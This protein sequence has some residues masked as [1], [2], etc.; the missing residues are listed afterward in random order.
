[1]FLA[2]EVQRQLK[3][4]RISRQSL[5][6]HANVAPVSF[7]LIARICLVFHAALAIAHS[8][9]D[10]SVIIHRHLNGQGAGLVGRGQA[11]A[12]QKRVAWNAFG[13]V[14]FQKV[15]HSQTRKSIGFFI[16][17]RGICL[18]ARVLP[19]HG[20]VCCRVAQWNVNDSNFDVTSRIIGFTNHNPCF[21]RP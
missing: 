10:D 14:K 9:L 12:E 3:Y 2:I 18:W 16:G 1:M 11:H 15:R 21:N 7:E 19:F 13:L 17:N 6:R 8:H 4:R 5:R 20:C